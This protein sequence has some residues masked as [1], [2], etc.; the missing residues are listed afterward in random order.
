[1][2]NEELNE[3]LVRTVSSAKQVNILT[4]DHAHVSYN[5]ADASVQT[6][7]TDEKQKEVV[8]Q[9]LPMFFGMENNA[10]DFLVAVQGRKPTQITALVNQWVSENKISEMSKN[11]DLWMVLHESGIYQKTESN[12]NSQVK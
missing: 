7:L 6:T 2:S 9:L 11:R 10:R 12:W 8:R 1:M 5:E 4:G 3:M